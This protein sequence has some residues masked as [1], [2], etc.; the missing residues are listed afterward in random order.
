M[1]TI[2][3]NIAF[4]TAL[5]AWRRDI[6]DTQHMPMQNPTDVG[7]NID[8]AIASL[9]M[10]EQMIKD[11]ATGQLVRNDNWDENK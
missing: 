8:Y 3:S 2:K 6:S 1:I 9:V 11:V 4:L 10:L 7:L 5:N